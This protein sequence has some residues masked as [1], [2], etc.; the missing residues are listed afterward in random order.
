MQIAGHLNTALRPIPGWVLYPLGLVPLGLLVWQTFTGGLGIDPVKALEHRLGE[1]GL[2]L[3]VAGLAVTPIRRLTGVNLIRYRRAIGLLAFL[4]VVLHFATWLFLD[5]QLRWGEIGADLTK[6]PYIMLG[7]LGLVALLPLALTSNNRSL[8]RMGAAAWQR[9]HR[10]A[11]VAA[12]AGAVHYMVLVKAWPL[13]PM[14]YL[15]AVV[16]LLGLRLVLRR[17]RPRRPA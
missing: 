7:M 8:R 10:L 14:L 13:Q 6:R 15:A 11:Y 2:Q 17:P 12:L 3:L 4:Y 16:G 1:I 9:L 5:I